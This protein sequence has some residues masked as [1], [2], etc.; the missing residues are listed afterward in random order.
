MSVQYCNGWMDEM[1]MPYLCSI[2]MDVVSMPCLCSIVMDVMSM[3]FLCSI[4]M[5]AMSMPCLCI[6]VM[7][8]CHVNAMSVRAWMSCQCHICTGVDVNICRENLG[9]PHPWSI[10]SGFFAGRTVCHCHSQ[11]P[12]DTIARPLV[13]SCRVIMPYDMLAIPQCYL[14]IRTARKCLTIR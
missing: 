11:M 6:I 3:P 5:D 9:N 12:Y 4:V 10:H 14:P 13:I 7:D 8:G 1:S 2:V